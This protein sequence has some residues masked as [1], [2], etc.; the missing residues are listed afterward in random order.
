M[1]KKGITFLIAIIVI[2]AFAI[3]AWYLGVFEVE[4]INFEETTADSDKVSEREKQVAEIF[5]DDDFDDDGITNTDEEAG[6]TDKT[7]ADSDGDGLNDGEELQMYNTDP[8]EPDTDGDS[9]LDGEEVRNGHDP[10]A[11]DK[12]FVTKETEAGVFGT[13]R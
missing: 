5:D 2:I 4:E 9:Y 8:M 6:G 13:D 3:G 1:S 12:D 11:T 7:K 10:L